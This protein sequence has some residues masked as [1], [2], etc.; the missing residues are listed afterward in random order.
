MYLCIDMKSFFAS[1]ECALR[2]LNSATTPLVVADSSRGDG[3]IV[4]AV[5]TYL[6]SLGVKNRCRIHEIPKGIKYIKAMPRM[7]FY[8]SYAKR[9][10]KIFL[11]YVSYQD[12]HTYSIDEAFLYVKPYLKYY[13]NSIKAL[14]KR[15]T[16]DIHNELGIYSTCGAGDNMYL[17]KVAL[18][19]LA[20]H[21]DGY[22]YLSEDLYIKKLWKHRP[23]TDFWQIGIRTEYHLNKLGIYTLED[24]A[25]SDT[26][27]LKKEFGVIGDEMYQHAWGK[28]DVTISDIKNYIPSNKSISRNQ[29]LFED[30]KKEDAII[31]LLEMVYKVC[32][33]MCVK[34]IDA[35]GIS[36]YI[37]YSKDI[38]GGYAKA[39]TFE[40]RCRDYQIISE[41]IKDV[42]YANVLDL[43]IRRVGVSF[44]EIEKIE[45][46]QMSL[47]NFHNDKYI[48]LCQS[49]G[50]IWNIHDKNAILPATSLLEKSTIKYRNKCI[51]GHNDE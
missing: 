2:G 32:I 3:A 29:I 19:I 38:D 30:Y 10:H 44:F 4:L 24:L 36:F 35:R 12:I 18:D 43:P 5:S 48:A 20:K 1:V 7:R 31:P 51:G 25:Y 16:N 45:N 11:K 49:I 28:D 8:I 17:S 22:Y 50:D 41:I 46:R 40:Y 14:A 26:N 27:M 39:I 21:N 34:N 13:G 23:L 37:G 6:K 33:D 9:I 15:I 42:Y 47:F